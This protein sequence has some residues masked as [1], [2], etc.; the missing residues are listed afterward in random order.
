MAKFADQLF[1]DLMREHGAALAHAAP[2]AITRR[3]VTTRRVML[4]AAGGVAAAATAATF[5]TGGGS[6][7]YAV[8]KNPDGTI[9]VA[10]YQKSGIAG[11]NAKIRTM[12]DRVV[13]VP[14]EAGCPTFDSLPT[15]PNLP[16]V[17][18][19]MRLE[20]SGDD[21]RDDSITL[22]AHGIRAG[23]V[24]VV[25]AKANGG[26]GGMQLATA[27]GPSCISYPPVQP[28]PSP[29]PSPSNLASGSTAHA[30]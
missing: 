13:V 17:I 25:A 22:D 1:D 19:G 27:P 10:V 12:G 3:H 2:Q 20:V 29:S 9:T 30:R 26:F 21:G 23:Y 18:R 28:N 7:A 11:A 8:T 16:A 24:L 6:P 15:I 4:A 5:V 14:V